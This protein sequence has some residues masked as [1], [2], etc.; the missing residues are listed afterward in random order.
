MS[1][2]QKTPDT[3]FDHRLE[4]N[5]HTAFITE[6]RDEGQK[7]SVSGWT[8][9]R[10][11][12]KEGQLVVFVNRDDSETRYKITKMEFPADVDDQYFMDCEFCPRT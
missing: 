1:T 9:D 10:R 6:I 8:F 3:H 7:I 11:R 12:F 2:N 5:G 4:I